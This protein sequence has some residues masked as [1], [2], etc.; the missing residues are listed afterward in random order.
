MSCCYRCIPSSVATRTDGASKQ[1]NEGSIDRAHSE[2][3]PKNEL[4]GK[5]DLK[6]SHGQLAILQLELK[7]ADLALK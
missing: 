5:S 1:N 6:K 7:A 2:E 4:E 3:Y